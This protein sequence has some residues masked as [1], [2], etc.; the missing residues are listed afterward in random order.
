MKLQT[1]FVA[2]AIA[3]AGCHPKPAPTPPTTC[4]GQNV[5]II[6][7][8]GCPVGDI[9][10]H[11][12]VCQASGQWADADNTCVMAPATCSGISQGVIEN[13]GCPA[14][15]TGDH[16]AICTAKGW[17]DVDNTCAVVP[18]PPPPPPPTP[19]APPAA[20]SVS[21]PQAY[22]VHKGDKVALQVRPA[23]G[24]TYKWSTGDTTPLIWV[25]PAADSVY[26]VTATGP[27]GS[28]SA[29]VS[30]VVE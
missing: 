15:E 14:G 25:S 28:A 29:S 10:L 18:P 13:V 20:P 9:G 19:P 16:H 23:D 11:T 26:T 3:L 4:D 2:I 7:S 1:L 5:G 17:A 6:R 21:L 27:G 30:V 8:L 24:V 12:Q 22:R